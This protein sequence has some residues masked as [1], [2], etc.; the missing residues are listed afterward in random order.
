MKMTFTTT[1]SNT[2][3]QKVIYT[4]K[5]FLPHFNLKFS[6]HVCLENLGGV[7]TKTKQKIIKKVGT[8]MVLRL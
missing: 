5:C 7:C 4:R 3:S 2:S 6:K 1:K 8:S